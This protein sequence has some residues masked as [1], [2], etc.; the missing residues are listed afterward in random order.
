MGGNSAGSKVWIG[1]IGPKAEFL[2]VMA[3]A[4][5]SQIKLKGVW[6]FDLQ[7]AEIGMLR[8]QQHI[9]FATN[10]FRDSSL[11]SCHLRGR[12]LRSRRSVATSS[13]SSAS[14]ETKSSGCRFGSR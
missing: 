8:V 14:I 3:L 2:R 7:L 1:R 10:V 9:P 4:E 13:G 6:S 11:S 5:H 12:D